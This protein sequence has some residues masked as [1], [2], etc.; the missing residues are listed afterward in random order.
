MTQAEAESAPLIPPTLPVHD[1]QLP[2]LVALWMGVRN[3]LSTWPR[4]PS[5]SRYGVR[6]FLAQR[7]W[8]SAIRPGFDRS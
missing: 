6:A 7:C 2:P 8:W 1:R 4:W 5:R 3:N